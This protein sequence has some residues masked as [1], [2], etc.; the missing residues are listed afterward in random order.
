M[1]FLVLAWSSDDR[2][3][4]VFG[5]DSAATRDAFVTEAEEILPKEALAVLDLGIFGSSDVTEAIDELVRLS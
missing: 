3:P 2:M 1:V 5:F 4:L